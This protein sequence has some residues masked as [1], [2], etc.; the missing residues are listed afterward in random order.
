MLDVAAAPMV[1]APNTSN[2]PVLVTGPSRLS[3]AVPVPVGSAVSVPSLSNPE[4]T[5]RVAPAVPW[6]GG[7]ACSDGQRASLRNGEL[8]DDDRAFGSTTVVPPGMHAST[9][10]V[11]GTTPVLQ[12]AAVVQSV[13]PPPPVQMSVQ[14]SAE[15]AAGATPVPVAPEMIRLPATTQRPAAVR[16]PEPQ[17]RVL[18]RGPV[19]SDDEVSRC[20]PSV[21]AACHAGR[22]VDGGQVPSFSLLLRT[23]HR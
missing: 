1:S 5:V 20:P 19:E 11:S 4:E 10:V 14:L 7:L 2:A 13:V 22:F 18:A 17:G 21:N 12:L 9:L 15:S 16:S 23:L 3:A 8:S 6:L